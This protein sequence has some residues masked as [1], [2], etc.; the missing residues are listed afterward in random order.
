MVQR[1][2]KGEEYN[3]FSIDIIH[4]FYATAASEIKT[5][6][7]VDKPDIIGGFAVHDVPLKDGTRTNVWIEY[8][9]KLLPIGVD[10][11][12]HECIL[13]DSDVPDDILD[14]MNELKKAFSKK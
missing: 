3:Y 8:N 14:R 13:F 6:K 10:V 11:G 4:S 2:Q 5:L 7:E 1:I 12:I 9:A